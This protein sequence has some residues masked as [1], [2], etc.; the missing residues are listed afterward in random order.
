MNCP[1][2]KQDANFQHLHNAAHGI[3]GTHLQGSE[4]YECMGCGY[5]IFKQEGVNLNLKFVL[6]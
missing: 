3:P 5:K 4:R 2:C 1:G 6:D